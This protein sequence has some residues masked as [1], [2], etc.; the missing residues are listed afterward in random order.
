MKRTATLVAGLLLVT[1]TIFAAPTVATTGEVSY[2][3]TVFATDKAILQNDPTTAVVNDDRQAF[4]ATVTAKFNDSNS[5]MVAVNEENDPTLKVEFTNTGKMNVFTATALSDAG[6][7]GL[8]EKVT[9][10]VVHT[11]GNVVAQV[12]GNLEATLYGAAATG[13]HTFTPD[14]GSDAIY[15]QYQVTPTIQT[16]FYP[17]ATTFGVDSVFNDDATNDELLGIKS[18]A[19]DYSAN[20]TVSEDAVAGVKVAVTAGMLK[21]LEVK[22]GTSV[23]GAKDTTYLVDA[24]YSTKV[25]MVTLKGDAA[26]STDNNNAL[27]GVAMVDAQAKVANVALQGQ[28]V[29]AIGRAATD[30]LS[31]LYVK[32]TTKM[33]G[34]DLLGEATNKKLGT[35]TAMTGVYLE[36]KYSLAEVQGIKPTVTLSF[37]DVDLSEKSVASTL[38]AKVDAS[39]VK[40]GIT[41]TPALEIANATKTTATATVEVKYTF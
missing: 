40:D 36:G 22:V 28:F 41:V 2:K 1:G 14:T 9:L 30:D 17:Y 3:N 11:K 23:D 6:E 26:L 10:G 39:I 4:S 38:T 32:A 5:L 21:G 24:M 35:N 19:K 18:T 13:K 7:T 25:G 34:V 16:T 33:A 12:K 20:E 29:S 15:L 8:F 37:K 27:K 31:L